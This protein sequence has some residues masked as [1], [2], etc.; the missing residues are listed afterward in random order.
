[1]LLDIAD[2]RLKVRLAVPRDGVNRLI[3]EYPHEPEYRDLVMGALANL[4]N[5][6]PA[7]RRRSSKKAA[8]NATA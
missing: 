2:E 6:R 7:S 1:M 4:I 5:P 8:S 3:I